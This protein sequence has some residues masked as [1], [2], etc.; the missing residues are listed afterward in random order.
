MGGVG[1]TT[2]QRHNGFFDFSD[3]ELLSFLTKS[4]SLRFDLYVDFFLYF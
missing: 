2:K 1:I 4:L 3:M